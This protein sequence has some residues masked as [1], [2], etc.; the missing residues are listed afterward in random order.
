M[1]DPGGRERYADGIIATGV[2]AMGNYDDQESDKEKL[3][4]EVID[5]QI[6][7]VG[8]QFLGHCLVPV[9]MITNSIRFRRPTITRWV[10]CS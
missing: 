9:A 8:R 6:D 4:A 1:E 3:Y 7:L 5:D 2:L 10:V